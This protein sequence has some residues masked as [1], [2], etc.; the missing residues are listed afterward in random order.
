M[1]SIVRSLHKTKTTSIR[2]MSSAASAA[3]R[4]AL[5]DLHKEHGAKFGPFAGWDMP[6]L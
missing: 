3:Q 5:Y 6:L 4:T 1:S 2:L